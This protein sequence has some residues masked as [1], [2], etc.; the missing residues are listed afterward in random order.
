MTKEVC[1]GVLGILF[2]IALARHELFGH[3]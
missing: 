3:G 1:S 2:A